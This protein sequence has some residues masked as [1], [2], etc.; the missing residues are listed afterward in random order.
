M[1]A[2]HV[3]F[4]ACVPHNVRKMEVVSTLAAAAAGPHW[5]TP[6]MQYAVQVCACVCACM[7]ARA[8]DNSDYSSHET[9][10]FACVFVALPCHGQCAP[11][12]KTADYVAPQLDETTQSVAPPL[13]RMHKTTYPLDEAAH[14]VSPLYMPYHNR[15]F[16][17]PCA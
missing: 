6:C 7:F 10:A 15:T 17:C 13:I 8:A 3:L 5:N 11:L 12:D 14:S 2:A 1:A 4:F 16:A 9:P